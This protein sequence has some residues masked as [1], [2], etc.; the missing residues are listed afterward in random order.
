MKD[1][2]ASLYPIDRSVAIELPILD[3]AY[4]VDPQATLRAIA[5]PERPLRR[6]RLPSGAIAWI[7]TD[8]QLGRRLLIDRRFS[9][10]PQQEDRPEHTGKPHFIFRHMLFRDPPEHTRLRALV[11]AFFRK[12]RIE[13]YRQGIQATC[14]QL[15]AALHQHR[16]I[17]LVAEFAKPLSLRTIAS[18]VGCSA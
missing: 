14:D 8:F 10:E 2:S 1:N 9:K 11:A 18:L 12:A 16:E 5:P 13:E 17:D 15:I 4:R 6:G 3:A 7:L